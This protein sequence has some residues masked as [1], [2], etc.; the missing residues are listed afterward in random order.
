MSISNLI[1]EMP[2]SRYNS[3]IVHSWFNFLA[4]CGHCNPRHDNTYSH[5]T[6]CKYHITP[7]SQKYDGHNQFILLGKN[8]KI[9]IL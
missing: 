7:E 1:K 5:K 4:A 2:I 8:T 3:G 6:F 9:G